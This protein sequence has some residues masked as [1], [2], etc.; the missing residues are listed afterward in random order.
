MGDIV[1]QPELDSSDSLPSLWRPCHIGNLVIDRIKNG[2]FV[3]RERFG[4][5]APFLN[6]ADTYRSISADLNTVGRASCSKSEIAEFM[7]QPGDLI[8]VRSS[9]KREGIGRCCIVESVSEPSIYD[10]H[11]MRVR[12]DQRRIIPK[13]LAYFAS[14]AHAKHDLIALSKTTTMTTLNQQGLSAFKVPLPPLDEQHHICRILDMSQRAKEA[15]EK[16]IAATRQL[17]RNRSR[18][19]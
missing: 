4:P 18:P 6:V 17:K 8:F 13:F 3:K 12:V 19:G 11:L 14:T 15:T 7:L 9:L 10:C 2:A 16:V 5:G 1:N